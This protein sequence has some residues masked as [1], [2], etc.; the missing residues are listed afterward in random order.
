MARPEQDNTII[1]FEGQ[2]EHPEVAAAQITASATRDAAII[3]ERSSTR[4]ALIYATSGITAAC[5]ALY[6]TIVLSSRPASIPAQPLEGPEPPSATRQPLA[7]EVQTESVERRTLHVA[8]PAPPKPLD[9]KSSPVPIVTPHQNSRAIYASTVDGL[10]VRVQP[11]GDSDEIASLNVGQEVQI[12][13][14]E[15][16]FAINHPGKPC[17]WTRV[18]FTDEGASRQGWCA[19]QFLTY[20]RGED[21]IRPLYQKFFA[22]L[23]IDPVIESSI[24]EPPVNNIPRAEDI[25]PLIR[26]STSTHHFSKNW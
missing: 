20:I 13:D 16:F 7:T 12:D 6:G 17:A 22:S 24:T 23:I 15:N 18:T 26:Q 25:V 19:V 3:A 21:F 1:S 9:S 2:H 4:S 8:F 14:S 10:C 11:D 5:I